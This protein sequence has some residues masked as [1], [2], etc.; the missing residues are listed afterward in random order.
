MT[1]VKKQKAD[2]F[3]DTEFD[4]DGSEFEGN[5]QSKL[6]DSVAD[7][8]FE[9]SEFEGSSDDLDP[10]EFDGDGDGNDELPKLNDV[11]VDNIDQLFSLVNIGS[12][13]RIMYWGKSPMNP[14]VRVPEFWTAPEFRLALTNK[15][16][17]V[18]VPDG[19]SKR[20][21][22]ASR[23][24][25]RRERYTYDGLIFNDKKEEVSEEDEINLWR[26]YG[27]DEHEADWSL[28]RDHIRNII[29][30]GDEASDD[31]I[32]RWLAWAVQNPTSHAGVAMVLM[33]KEHGTGKGTLGHAMRNMFG[34]H[35]LHLTNRNHVVGKFNAHFMQ[36]GFLFCDE[37]LWPGN[38][39]DEGILKGLISEQTLAIEPKGLNLFQM[40]NSLKVLLASNQDWVIP[41]VEDERRYAVFTVNPSRKQ[42]PDYFGSLHRQLYKE[43]GISGMLYDLRQMDLDG[44][45]PHHNIPQT[46]ALAGQKMESA[47][48]QI[49]WLAGF[50]NEGIL[51]YQHDTLPNRARAT[52][53]YNNAIRVRG[54][55][56][57]TPYEVGRFLDDWKIKV[58]RSNGSWRVFPPLL[59]LRADWKRRMPWWEDFDPKITSWSS[60][61]YSQ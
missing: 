59:E 28:M 29:A 7:T 30:N 19:E 43:G 15:K 13:V 39:Q 6:D 9:G 1:I 61:P 16:I 38:K 32:I 3:K 54:L 51:P 53:L 5:T 17:K 36:I 40:P 33:S 31:Y 52:D 46:S 42:D 35:G 22:L 44:W 60:N 55:E 20:M 47:P 12:K 21:S 18:Q 24:L 11:S 4:A 2:P 26:G 14:R 50:L 25:N 57:W 56:Y 23:W 41:A 49:K 37:V 34:N 48:P 10:N 45:Q 8:E 58:K 27:V